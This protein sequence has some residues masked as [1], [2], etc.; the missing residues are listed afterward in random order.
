[1]KSKVMWYDQADAGGDGG[2]N[3]G[4][5]GDG[6]GNCVHGYGMYQLIDL[7]NSI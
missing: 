5:D 1:M 3:G 7:Q 2:R 4:G 6:G